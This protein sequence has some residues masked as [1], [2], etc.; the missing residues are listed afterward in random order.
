[1]L[2]QR[3]LTL[4]RAA[5][6]A[7]SATLLVAGLAPASLGAPPAGGDVVK[8][9]GGPRYPGPAPTG[10][11]EDF[12]WHL[13]VPAGPLSA[14]GEKLLPRWL[15]V[16]TTG[17][18]SSVVAMPEGRVRWELTYGPQGLAEKVETVD[19]ELFVR[20]TYAYDDGG[21]LVGKEAT[22]PGAGDGGRTTFTY[23]NDASGRVVERRSSQPWDPV[24]TYHRTAR[25]VTID[26]AIGGKRVR[27][28]VFDTSG[29]RVLTRFLREQKPRVLTY[30]RSAGAL[31]AVTRIGLAR[32][33]AGAATFDGPPIDLDPEDVNAVALLSERHEV[34]LMLGAPR[35]ASDSGKGAQRRILAEYGDDTCWLNQ[36][37]GFTFTA[38][39]TYTDGRVGCMCGLC[40][41]A[42]LPLAGDGVEAVDEHWTAG[43]WVRLDGAVDVTADHRVIT[44]SGPR[45]AGEL[46]AGDVVVGADGAPR[47]L[48][49]VEALP[50]GPPRLGVNLETRAGAFSAGGFLFESEVLSGCAGPARER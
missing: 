36:V 8:H 29:R 18:V 3:P 45:P 20:A 37:S 5:L 50:L 46:R 49:S 38:D 9:L 24:L 2:T 1:M 6:A 25:D 12:A 32:P 19:G 33:N 43:P 27:S 35:T 31:V 7:L 47:V 10:H 23:R 40:V 11:Y 4:A 26:W 44:P 21:R 16:T 42:A 34:L 41:D 39:G 28:D 17:S 13:G 14:A 22:G 48:R 15:D 30:L